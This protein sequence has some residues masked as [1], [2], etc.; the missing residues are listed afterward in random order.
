MVRHFAFGI[1]LLL[2]VSAP[3][4]GAELCEKDQAAPQRGAGHPAAAAKPDKPKDEKAQD[5]K[6][7]PAPRLRWWIDAKLRA[8]LGIN[9]Q[10]SAAVEKVWNASA[11]GLSDLRGKLLKLEET[12]SQMTDSNAD[13]KAVIA[14]IAIVETTRAELNKGRTLMIYRMNKLLSVD[15]RAKVKAMYERREPNKRGSSLR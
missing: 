5:D 7:H 15:Q 9:D 6:D 13:E 11:P 8:E 1:A 14:Q 10:Q 12:L 3:G 2:L 4:R